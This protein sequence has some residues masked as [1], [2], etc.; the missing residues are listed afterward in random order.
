M[1][2]NPGFVGEFY[3]ITAYLA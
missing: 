2:S 1:S 3:V